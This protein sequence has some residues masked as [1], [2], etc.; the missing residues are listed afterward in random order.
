MVIRS[1][2]RRRPSAASIQS[3]S[4]DGT[5]QRTRSLLASAVCGTCF[6][7][8][9]VA[10]GWAGSAIVSISTLP[11]IVARTFHPTPAA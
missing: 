1:R 6:P 9:L 4:I 10:R 8:I 2:K 5:S 7:S 11:E 3:L